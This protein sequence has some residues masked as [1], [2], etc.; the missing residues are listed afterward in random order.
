MRKVQHI[1]LYI[2][3]VALVIGCGGRENGRDQQHADS[4]VAAELARAKAYSSEQEGTMDSARIILER[5]VRQEGLSL[6]QK[7]DVLG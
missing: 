4:L 6:E 5:L 7:A 2:V 1:I 3:I